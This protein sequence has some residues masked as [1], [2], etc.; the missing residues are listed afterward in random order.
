M[1]YVHFLQL[2][3]FLILAGKVYHQKKL[4]NIGLGPKGANPMV[5]IELR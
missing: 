5:S 3:Q 2:V 1:H 4:V